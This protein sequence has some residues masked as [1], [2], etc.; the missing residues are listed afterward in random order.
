MADRKPGG[1]LEGERTPS[2]AADASRLVTQEPDAPTAAG[3]SQ[4]LRNRAIPW[5]ARLPGREG[6][7]EPL[8]SGRSQAV[9]PV[10]GTRL[11]GSCNA[12]AVS[13]LTSC[14]AG[15]GAPTA[16]PW[17]AASPYAAAGMR[18]SRLPRRPVTALE[19]RAMF[20][21]SVGGPRP[22][23][24]RSLARAMCSA[25]LL[26]AARPPLGPRTCPAHTPGSPGLFEDRRL[27]HGRLGGGGRQSRGRGTTPPYRDAPR[28]CR[29]GDRGLPGPVV[30]KG[31]GRTLKQMV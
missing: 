6:V 12:L 29:A 18:R 21:R 11:G 17:N 4:P 10:S 30:D 22:G 23:P 16:G 14:F 31:G 20:H 13:R 15:A 28:T 8:S 9:L 26:Q 24:R 27:A 1:P 25:G 5:R 7:V 19:K 3:R 2:A